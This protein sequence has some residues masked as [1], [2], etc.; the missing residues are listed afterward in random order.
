[1]K[2]AKAQRSEIKLKIQG[3]LET[4]PNIQK[5]SNRYVVIKYGGSIIEDGVEDN[6]ISQVVFLKKYIG[7]NMI[8]VHGGGRQVDEE[9]KKR[10]LA[11]S[12]KIDGK[13]YTPKNILPILDKCFGE[14]NSNIVLKIRKMGCEAAGL[15]SRTKTIVKVKKDTSLEL[16]Y[17]GIITSIDTD[18]IKQLPQGCI[19]VIS[20]LGVDKNGQLYNVNADDVASAVSV[21]LKAAK[22]IVLTD[23]KGIK[24]GH[25][26]EIFSTLTIN[27]VEKLIKKGIVA[28]GMIPKLRA[29]VE[30][31]KKGVEKVH[32]IKGTDENS[33]IEEILSTE[34][35]GTQIIK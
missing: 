23:V 20:S 28:G 34:G 21:A 19:P 26:E 17:V 24:T 1:M 18:R 5:F 12:K 2:I 32:I 25:G 33:I 35:V 10:G 22:F 15:H 8:I 7:I 9:I 3:L 14:L 4:L 13:R 16:G 29:S 6:I 30:V 31:I 27:D 11:P